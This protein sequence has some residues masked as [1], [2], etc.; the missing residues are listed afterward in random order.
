MIMGLV[1]SVPH[2][3]LLLFLMHSSN[4]EVL[5]GDPNESRD[6]SRTVILETGIAKSR[7]K[8]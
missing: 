4:L 7:L 1:G 3:R 6:T 2:I 8:L 5:L